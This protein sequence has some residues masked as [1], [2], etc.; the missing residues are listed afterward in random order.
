VDPLAEKFYYN[1]TFAFSE[2]RVIDGRELE[3]LEWVDADGNIIYDPK[4]NDGKGGYTEYASNNDKRIGNLLRDSGETGQAQFDKLVNAE[5]PISINVEFSGVVQDK[6]GNLILGTTSN[7]FNKELGVDGSPKSVE[8]VSSKITIYFGSI[9]KAIE[10]NDIV[11]GM[12]ASG[13]QSDDI[14]TANLGH[15]IEHTTKENVLIDIV[16]RKDNEK[17]AIK[18]GNKILNDIKEKKRMISNILQKILL[19]ISVLFLNLQL[20]AQKV[21]DDKT[22]N[23]IATH[24]IEYLLKT[25]DL[26]AEVGWKDYDGRVHIL[27][28]SD[29]TAL[30]YKKVGIYRV[31]VSTSHTKKYLLLKSNKRYKILDT[32]NFGEV[33]KSISSFLLKHNIP[34]EEKVIYVEVLLN[35]YNMNKN[36]NPAKLSD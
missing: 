7:K 14:F 10:R 29:N 26:K 1:S 5:H 16:E 6:N 33:L 18:I 17:P 4:A 34:D 2:N 8:M 31:L 23:K 24:A 15:E 35:I 20:S 28:L 19:S 3:G 22:I 12:Q 25:G 21:D 11:E 36:R 30:G 27:E 32:D 13:F 9:D